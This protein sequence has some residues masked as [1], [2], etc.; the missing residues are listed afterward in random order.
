[1]LFGSLTAEDERPAGAWHAEWQ[2]L[3]EALRLAGGAARDA[4]ELAE[5]L[6]VHP[7]RMRE[8]LA[9][10]G[11]LIVSERLAASL[12]PLVGRAEAKRALTAA[13]RCSAEEGVA[14]VDVLERDPAVR[15]ALSPQALRELA[16]PTSYLG[17]APAR[18]HGAPADL[19]VAIETT[20]GLAV[21]RLLAAGHPIVPVHP[22]AFHAMRAHW[23]ASKAKTDAGDS[24]KLAD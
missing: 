22:N 20:R 2:P 11:G 7:D 14:L 24:F 13:A 19:P 3:G 9:A 21:D 4:R 6:T 8:N 5:G 1:M 12:A 15:D 10:T 23:G 17:A 16:D 18:K